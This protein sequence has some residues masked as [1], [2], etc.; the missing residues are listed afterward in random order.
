MYGFLIDILKLISLILLVFYFQ[1][2]PPY[3]IEPNDIEK[4]LP[5]TLK[6]Y[7]KLIF[8]A[9]EC[10][11]ES[12]DKSAATNKLENIEIKQENQNSLENNENGNDDLINTMQIKN[13]NEMAS[14]KLEF[15]E[16]KEEIPSTN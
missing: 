2:P 12:S 11:L 10:K 15:N 5:I 14:V 1:I 6:T 9:I 8:N 3:F 4:H 7:D 16:I 13:S